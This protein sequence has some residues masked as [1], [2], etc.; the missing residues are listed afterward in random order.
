MSNKITWEQENDTLIENLFKQMF[1]HIQRQIPGHENGFTVELFITSEC[2]QRCEYCYLV[3]HGHK[4]Y[5]APARDHATILHNMDLLFNYLNK[6]GLVPA[7]IDIF[8]GEIWCSEFGCQVLQ[9]LLDYV[10]NLEDPPHQIMIPSNFSFILEEKYL[11]AIEYYINAFDYYNV[12]L[13]FSCSNDGG[14]L[15]RHSR[16]FHSAEKTEMKDTEEY[17]KMLFE[18]CRKHHFGFHPM[19]SAYGIEQWGEQYKWWIDKIKEYD[20]DLYTSIMFLEVRNNEWTEDKVKAY[21]EYLN[22]AI[23]Y[24]LSAYYDGD[25]NKIVSDIINLPIEPKRSNCVLKNYSHLGLGDA[26]KGMSCSIERA[27]M[28]R[29]GDLAWIPC[30]RTGYDKFLFGTFKVENDEIVGIKA[31]N[32]PLLFSIHGVG[33]QGHMKCDVCPIGAICPRGCYGAQFEHSKELFYPCPTVCDLY[34][35]KILMLYHKLDY[36]VQ[37]YG[38]NFTHFLQQKDYLYRHY[39]SQIPRE[40]Y[41]KWMPTIERLIRNSSEMRE[42]C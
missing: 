26:S 19:V 10:K 24:T 4:L 35:A 31:N 16:P 22:T 14:I 36:Y 42:R 17:Y 30:H 20:M 7:H 37:T 29:L 5:P 18:F 9:K 15:D 39:I 32:L 33:Y 3:K 40:E 6:N 25:V 2:D 8:T 28:I 23:D 38:C 1:S 11:K 21:L 13:A 12:N 41:D 34:F 27:A